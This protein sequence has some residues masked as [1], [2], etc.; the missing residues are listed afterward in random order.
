M[1]KNVSTKINAWSLILFGSI[2]LIT[3]SVATFSNFKY[4]YSIEERLFL[5]FEML[6]ASLLISPT[7]ISGIST[8]KFCKDKSIYHFCKK[9]NIIGIIEYI[10][11]FFIILR[12]YSIYLFQGD[13]VKFI[14][15]LIIS[16]IILLITD[17]IGLYKINYGHTNQE[18]LKKIVKSRITQI[19]IALE[20]IIANLLAIG[21]GFFMYSTVHP[22]EGEIHPFS[23]KATLIIVLFFLP[24]LMAGI[25]TLIYM[26][27]GKVRK[28]III[29]NIL[30]YILLGI[31][32]LT[33]LFDFDLDICVFILVFY[34]FPRIINMFGIHEYKKK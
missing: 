8:L 21:S 25:G 26:Y 5:V 22:E 30:T 11:T 9:I 7:I 20:S 28:F 34:I 2:S 13:I 19:I 29:M 17:M 3:V 4:L 10:I 27:N 32:W 18:T 6:G 23:L 15:V 33:F 31:I 12:V 16:Y 1:E 14:L 24:G